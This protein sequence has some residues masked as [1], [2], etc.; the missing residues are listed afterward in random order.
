[1][2]E[3]QLK[4]LINQ[5]KLEGVLK[6]KEE[7]SQIIGDANKKAQ[8]IISKAHKEAEELVNHAKNEAERFRA[9]SEKAIEQAGRNLILGISE[10]IE[11]ILN[12]V[13]KEN[14]NETLTPDFLK[15][16]I[17]RFVESRPKEASTSLE[18][19][20]NEKDKKRLDNII[21]GSLVSKIKAGFELKAVEGVKKGIL[22]GQK[23]KN[24][25]F[26]ISDDGIVEALQ[27][28]LNPKLKEII[29]KSI[30]KES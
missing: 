22:I 18:I 11:K 29:K 5:I 17:L 24:V 16:I 13:L 23:D 25:F 21:K 26:D 19:L 14:V 8:E 15:E 7:A 10:Q 4:D 20:L 9:N 2:P 6:A 30:K 3:T 12:S 1:M 27:S 28:Y